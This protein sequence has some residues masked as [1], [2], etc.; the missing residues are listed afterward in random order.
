[1]NPL[2]I[3]SVV[4][5]CYLFIY[6]FLFSP[7]TKNNNK[8]IHFEQALAEAQAVTV[9]RNEAKHQ[10]LV[11]CSLCRDT[12][13][14]Y[15]EAH[16]SL[17]LANK[18]T[19][20][21]LLAFLDFKCQFFLAKAYYYQALDLMNP[22]DPALGRAIR[23]FDSAVQNLDTALAIFT[24]FTTLAPKTK[25]SEAFEFLELTKEL[26]QSRLEKV[27]GH[28]DRLY[29][30]RISIEVDP[31]PEGKSNTM[32][33]KYDFPGVNTAF[34]TPQVYDSLRANEDAI[35]AARN[36]KVSGVEITS[37]CFNFK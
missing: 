23:S 14:R 11:V 18:E 27:Q 28:N 32:P 7:T 21:K 10:P 37:K 16:R 3:L 5:R 8:L 1:M 15:A 19:D 17:A 12:S 24:R 30:D 20:K 2:S 35:T 31:L 9:V 6:L 29:N 4:V 34:W 13:E 33:I 26:Y 25:G 22:D 36:G